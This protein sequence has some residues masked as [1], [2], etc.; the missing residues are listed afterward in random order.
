MSYAVCPTC[1]GSGHAPVKPRATFDPPKMLVD[2]TACKGIG[3]VVDLLSGT[4]SAM[5][6]CAACH[7]IGKVMP[8]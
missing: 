8:A 6:I 5:V 4:T 1:G 7:G 2:C 3:F